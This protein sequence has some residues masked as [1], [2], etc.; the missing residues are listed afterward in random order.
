MLS[1]NGAPSIAP[2]SSQIQSPNP[3]SQAELTPVRSYMNSSLKLSLNYPENWQISESGTDVIFATT[4]ESLGK[5]ETRKEELRVFI[6]RTPLLQ[7]QNLEKYISDIDKRSKPNIFDQKSILVDR[8]KAIRRVTSLGNYEA[9]VIYVQSG[10]KIYTISATPA[11]STFMPAFD[12]M[13]QS[14]KFLP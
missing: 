12:Q 2:K 5:D 10:T 6:G 14:F 9:I 11:D 3:T 13:L 1:K 4:K 8:E 7:G